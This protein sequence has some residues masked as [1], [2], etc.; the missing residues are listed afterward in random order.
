MKIYHRWPLSYFS[1]FL[2]IVS[3]LIF[4]FFTAMGNYSEQQAVKANA[5]FAQNALQTIDSLLKFS[6]QMLSKYSREATTRR[7]K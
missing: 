3:I 4:L 5:V 1:V 6:D 2:A 7:S